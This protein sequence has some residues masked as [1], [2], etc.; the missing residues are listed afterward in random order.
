MRWGGYPGGTTAK[1]ALR[2][3]ESGFREGE[4]YYAHAGYTQERNERSASHPDEAPHQQGLCS[5]GILQ[6]DA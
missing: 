3:R 6:D 1:H 5:I 4:E 2:P